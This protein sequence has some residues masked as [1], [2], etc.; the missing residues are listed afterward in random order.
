MRCYPI[1]VGEANA[2]LVSK[3]ASE[4]FE[5]DVVD[6]D[7]DTDDD[8]DDVLSGVVD[9]TAR[10]RTAMCGYMSIDRKSQYHITSQYRQ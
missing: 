5:T 4:A 3:P 2:L 6:D 8:D 1:P 7:S 10:P 9:S